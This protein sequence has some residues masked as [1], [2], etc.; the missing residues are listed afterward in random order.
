MI[1]SEPTLRQHC[2]V[3]S[4][5]IYLPFFCHHRDLLGH[6]LLYKVKRENKPRKSKKKSAAQHEDYDDYDNCNE[7]DDD[8]GDGGG[9]DISSGCYSI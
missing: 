8:H 5:S 2:I 1:P 7:D 6:S 3:S 9:I 4:S